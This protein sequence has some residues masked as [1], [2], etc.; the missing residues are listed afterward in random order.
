MIA[1][2]R[3]VP[4]SLAPRDLVDRDLIQ[5]GEPVLVQVLAGDALDDPPDGVP[6]DP[7][8]PA[9]R[10]LIRL[11]RQPSVRVEPG[12]VATLPDGCFPG[13]LSRIG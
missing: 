6:V 8:E 1:D 4:V 11:G 9:G 13:P 7:N 2:Q 10:C 12:R 5:V 3:Q